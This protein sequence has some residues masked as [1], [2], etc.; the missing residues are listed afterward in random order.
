M[1]FAQLRDAGPKGPEQISEHGMWGTKIKCTVMS[2]GLFTLFLETVISS[3]LSKSRGPPNDSRNEVL[4]SPPL[5]RLLPYSSRSMEG[6]SLEQ[7]EL[8]RKPMLKLH[9]IANPRSQLSSRISV[10][11][12][13][14][15]RPLNSDMF[16]LQVYGDRNTGTVE[17]QL[18]CRGRND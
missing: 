18:L 10:A 3:F 17:I 11:R 12:K 2:T 5:I 6:C 9:R 16:F 14:K 15:D 4:H 8:L 7:A 1:D 13:L